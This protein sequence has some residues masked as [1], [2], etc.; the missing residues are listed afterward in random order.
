MQCPV[1]SNTDIKQKFYLERTVKGEL[2]SFAFYECSTCNLMTAI[3]KNNKNVKRVYDD[4]F[5][6]S[7]QQ[8]LDW[9]QISKSNHP[10]I[11]NSEIR[12]NILKKFLKKNN[13]ILDIGAG[14]GIFVHEANKFFPTE[15]VELS[16]K[17]VEWANTQRIPVFRCNF[18]SDPTPSSSYDC[19]T[20]WDVLACFDNPKPVLQKAHALLNNS[21]YFVFTV[22]NHRALVS[23]LLGKAWPLLIPPINQTYYGKNTTY[24]LLHN[25][26]FKLLQFRSDKKWVTLDFFLTKIFR[27][28]LKS[29]DYTLPFQIPTII[30]VP[31][32]FGDVNF[33]IA[34]KT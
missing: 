14:K 11:V 3:P 5:H 25:N 2:S 17:A 9:Q 16:E 32:A 31:V 21:G 30:K 22:P 29:Q 6:S 8:T 18:L 7:S 34:Q 27:T 20:M 26:G 19:I 23:R 1:C 15:G 4:N 10:L 12:L 28:A 33:V 24:T 13:S